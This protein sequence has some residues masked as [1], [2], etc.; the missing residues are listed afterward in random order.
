MF[1]IFE[2]YATIII[3]IIMIDVSLILVTGIGLSA[4]TFIRFA[5]RVIYNWLEEDNE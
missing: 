3:L 2:I 1:E 4:A 5:I